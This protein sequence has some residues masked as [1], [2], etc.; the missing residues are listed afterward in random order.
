MFFAS[1]TFTAI[2]TLISLVGIAAGLVV[3]FGMF[4]S[5]P[6]NTWTSI[7]LWSTV[8]TSATGF[9]FPFTKFLPSH[10][11]G[12]LSLVLLAVALF[13]RYQRHMSGGWRVT[14]VVTAVISLYLN[15]FVLVVQLF[16][17]VPA[18]HALAPT[19]AEPPFAIA[20]GITLV[21]FIVAGVLA[22][23]RFCAPMAMGKGALRTA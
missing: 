16:L 9:L 11:V 5:K 3:L 7:F 15:C 6:L 20:Q 12:V 21:A 14:Y 10:A 22:V 18:L 4:A 19:Q 2:H 17:K 23:K 13:A 1:P 8:A